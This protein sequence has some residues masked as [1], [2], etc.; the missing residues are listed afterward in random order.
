M[1]NANAGAHYTELA[2]LQE[3]KREEAEL[4]FAIARQSHAEA[5]TRLAQA[6]QQAD[7]AYANWMA[8]LSS[9]A[10]DPQHLQRLT[11]SLLDADERQ[12]RLHEEAK[13]TETKVESGSRQA[14]EESL[15]AR[16]V[17]KLARAQSTKALTKR[18]E[19]STRALE[20]RMAREWKQP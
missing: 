1:S 5:N 19:L 13:A 14:A 4:S 3:L 12:A 16:H 17:H 6:Q 9:G 2:K 10:I 7:G 20:D 15:R 8:H 11:I 18:E